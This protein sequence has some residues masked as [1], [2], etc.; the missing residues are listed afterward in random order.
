[1]KHNSV[2]IFFFGVMIGAIMI[3]II[4][5]LCTESFKNMDAINGK[6]YGIIK[7]DG[8]KYFYRVMIDT[9]KTDSLNKWR[10]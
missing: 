3:L 7:E 1:M 10:K 4:Y 5:E 2:N 6:A 8:H 9:V